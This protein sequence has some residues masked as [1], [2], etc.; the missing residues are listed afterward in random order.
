[1]LGG[2][3]RV[4]PSALRRLFCTHTPSDRQE[5]HFEQRAESNSKSKKK[6]KAK[7][8]NPPPTTKNEDSEIE[9]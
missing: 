2:S 7:T 1:M 8:K 4:V 5:D 6:M 9:K 3:P